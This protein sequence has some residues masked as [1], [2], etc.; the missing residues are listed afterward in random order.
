M[1]WKNRL[2]QGGNQCQT[3]DTKKTPPLQQSVK[4]AK[5]LLSLPEA[6]RRDA[7]LVAT[8]MLKSQLQPS[9]KEADHED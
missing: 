8:R 6:T 3:P 2:S 1:V 7:I 5:L 9:L 4:L